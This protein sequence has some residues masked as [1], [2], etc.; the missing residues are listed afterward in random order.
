MR[1]RRE[2][3]PADSYQGFE[4]LAREHQE[5]ID[6]AIHVRASAR[7]QIA[8][9][10]PHGGKI[11]GATSDIARLIAGEEHGLYL[12]EGLRSSGDNFTRLH[13]TSHYFDEPRCLA[14]L[15][16]CE[17]AIAIHGYAAEGAEVLLGGLDIALKNALASAMRTAGLSVLSEG[18]RYPGRDPL[19]VCNRT[20]SGKGVQLEL[21]KTLRRSR[22]WEGLVDAVQSVLG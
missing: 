5:G 12:F 6:F 22:A 8:I 21:S 4:D 9:L 2:C 13:L 14:L 1:N 15:A 18:H 16:E 3:T 10:A 17:T 19:N 20:R 11:E 7:S